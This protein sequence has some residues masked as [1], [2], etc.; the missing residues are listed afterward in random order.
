MVV[1]LT[2]TLTWMV[3]VHMVVVALT[4]ALTCM[5]VIMVVVALTQTLTWMVAVRMVVVTISF[6]V[7][8]G[9]TPLVMSSQS[10]SS[11]VTP[12]GAPLV[13]KPVPSNLTQ[14]CLSQALH[15]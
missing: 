5:V 9:S 14:S 11:L 3:A 2:Q 13:K 4:R 6:M 8:P 12:S 15:W 10:P 1:A 7:V